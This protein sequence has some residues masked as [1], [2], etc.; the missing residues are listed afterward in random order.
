MYARHALSC[1]PLLML[2]QA[3]PCA[4]AGSEQLLAR[5]VCRGATLQDRQFN[6]RV[7][8]TC[9]AACADACTAA[10]AAA[11]TAATARQFDC[12]HDT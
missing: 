6:R 1:I 2:R 9:V 10:C 12:H 5:R 11:P 3:L 4:D 7:C 8:F